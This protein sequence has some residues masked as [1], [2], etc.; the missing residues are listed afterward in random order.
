MTTKKGRRIFV[1]DRL[2]EARQHV[3][4]QR[5]PRLAALVNPV[6][7]AVGDEIA[8]AAADIGHQALEDL[9]QTL[10]ARLFQPQFPV[11]EFRVEFGPVPPRGRDRESLPEFAEAAREIPRDVL[12]PQRPAREEAGHD[13]QHLAR[14]RRLDDVII[15]APPDGLVHGR[16]LLAL[17]DHDHGEARSG[18]TDP[19]EDLD[20]AQPGHPLVEQH[21]V[22]GG[23]C[24]QLEGVLTVHHGIDVIPRRPQQHEMGP[25][26]FDFV[27]HP[28]HPARHGLRRLRHALPF[29]YRSMARSSFSTT[30]STRIFAMRPGRVRR[31]GRRSPS[32][33]WRST[34][35]SRNRPYG[36][37]RFGSVY[38]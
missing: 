9:A 13:R 36:P 37:L 35:R 6:R 18:A 16:L 30:S 33:L 25:Q 1:E 22:I 26:E 14:A 8:E 3:H 15:R 31:D 28:Q 24:Q 21:E 27:V 11:D 7:V 20:A 17:R 38:P 23:G 5:G 19:V 10:L 2:E 32:R 34:V 4:R 29:R 12:V